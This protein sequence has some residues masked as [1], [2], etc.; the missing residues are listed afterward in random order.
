MI[1]EHE[2]GRGCDGPA[3]APDGGPML[4]RR[5][6]R[7]GRRAFRHFAWLWLLLGSPFATDVALAAETAS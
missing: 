1:Q 3:M 4:S 2:V 5:P 6:V 7:A